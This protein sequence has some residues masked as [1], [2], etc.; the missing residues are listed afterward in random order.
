M[1]TTPLV[2]GRKVAR[3]FVPS[4]ERPAPFISS[5]NASVEVDALL[6]RLRANRESEVPRD[7]AVGRALMP[8][9]LPLWSP[10]LVPPLGWIEPIAPAEEQVAE[11]LPQRTLDGSAGARRGFWETPALATTTSLTP[12]KVEKPFSMLLMTIGFIV[13]LLLFGLIMQTRVDVGQVGQRV[14]RVELGNRNRDALIKRFQTEQ[15][16]AMAELATK[17]E[18]VR[19][20]PSK[21]LNAQDLFQAGRY[22]EAEGIYGALLAERPNSALVPVI[23]GNSALANAMLGN[24]SMVQGRLNQMKKSAQGDAL[25]RR[26]GQLLEECANQRKTRRHG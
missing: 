6:K 21:F 7:T 20:P 5:S 9:P 26:A 15:G 16:T 19:R 17:F 3:P 1:T 13:A 10:T 4:T 2:P 23:L 12:V 25:L 24:C 14:D 8:R 11:D 22:A 18:E